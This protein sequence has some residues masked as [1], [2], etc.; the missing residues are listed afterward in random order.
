MRV[1]VRLRVFVWMR[2]FVCRVQELLYVYYVCMYKCV[3][4]LSNHIP[5][6]RA[7]PRRK[8]YLTT[9]RRAH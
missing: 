2:M 7:T 1:H 8:W 9:G 3:L 4:E 5:V 6:K